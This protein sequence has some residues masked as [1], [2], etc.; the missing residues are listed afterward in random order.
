[1]VIIQPYMPN[2]RKHNQ[3]HSN[4]I[5]LDSALWYGFQSHAEHCRQCPCLCGTL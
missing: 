4:T 3:G 5:S 1:M 2:P